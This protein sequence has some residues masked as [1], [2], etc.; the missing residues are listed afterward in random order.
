MSITTEVNS[1]MQNI[2]NAYDG[3]EDLGVDLT[4]VDKNINNI[5]SMLE[6][7]WNEYPKV[8]ATDVEEATLNGT[9]KGRMEIDLKG[10]TQQDGEPTPESP[11]PIKN[12]TGQANVKIQNKNLFDITNI[13]NTYPSNLDKS[14]SNNILDIKANT[15]KG[16]QYVG[17]KIFGLDSSKTYSLSYKSKKVVKGTD[18]QPRIRCTI[19][20]SNDNTNY[21]QI[22]N[23]DESNPTQGTE[24]SFSTTLTGYTSYRLY[25][26]NNLSNPVTLGENTQYYNIQLEE[27]STATS[28]VP[29]QEQNYPFTFAEGQR[30]MQGTKHKDDGIHNARTHI[31]LD[32]TENITLST[33]TVG[34]SNYGKFDITINKRTITSSIKAL[35]SH[36]LYKFQGW[37]SAG[38]ENTFSFTS[39]T[40]LR[41][42]LDLNEFD[43]VETL[44]TFL[45]NNEVTFEIILETEEIIPYNSTQQAQYNAKKQ[46][47]SYDDIT[48]ITSTSDEL[49][50]IMDI[51][52]LANA[53]KV[54]NSFDTRLLALE[55]NTNQTRKSEVD[56]KNITKETAENTAKETA[57]DTAENAENS[58]E[59]EVK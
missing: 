7:V 40:T 42:L 33:A 29:H 13:I 34:T 14:T 12:V 30:G 26:Y 31:T 35:S 32:G 4:D 11:V 22:R 54:I 25:F 1:I 15:T 37:T 6:N 17:Y 50:F 46:A 52:S 16:A 36:F 53:N 2:G 47:R 43:S 5:A 55:G 51:E 23:V 9:K 41:L 10:Q 44:R 38:N 59:S 18:G 45:T 28:Y 49:G 24:Y 39:P 20:G 19:A 8:T 58:V 56:I 21:T 3:L 57:E 48:Y 27:G